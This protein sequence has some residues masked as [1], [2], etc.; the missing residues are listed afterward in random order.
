[1]TISRVTKNGKECYKL[2]A[3]TIDGQ[4]R[5]FFFATK[6]EAQ[7]KLAELE[8]DRREVG[9]AWADLPARERVEAVRVIQEMRAAGVT[10]AGVWQAYRAGQAGKATVSRT[11]GEVIGE[12]LAA[13]RQAKRREVYLRSL[14]Q[15]LKG[16][17]KGRE[18][19]A[20]ASVGL[21]WVETYLGASKSLGSRMTRLNRLST[22]LAF[23]V[24]RGYLQ[25]NPC[26]A[27]ERA[28]VELPP[29][30]VLSVPQCR[31]LLDA[32]READAA[33]LPHLALCLFAG[34]RPAEARRLAWS[35][36]DLGAGLLTVGAADAKTRQRRVVELPSACVAWL[37]LGGDL[38][39]RNARHRLSSVAKLAG[40]APWP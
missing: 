11:L 22:L 26:S 7:R 10:L 25:A 38:P 37:R 39:A 27:V 14:E 16:F 13:K 28:S 33:F 1:M 6:K 34:V 21:E 2:D 19:V 40:I 32:T 23:A 17:A 35:A 12:L 5:R 31:A 9:R 24:R 29:P 36:I 3:G 30:S 4:R 8:Q 15:H 20:I 18:G